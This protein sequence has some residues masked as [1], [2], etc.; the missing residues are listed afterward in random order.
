[1]NPLGRQ[2]KAE[3]GSLLRSCVVQASKTLLAAQLGHGRREGPLVT[4]REEQVL[5]EHKP[6][7]GGGL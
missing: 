7:I 2:M 1:M 4:P 5:M 6:R 3:R